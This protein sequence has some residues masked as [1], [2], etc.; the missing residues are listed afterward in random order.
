M[1]EISKFV[2]QQTAEDLTK[3]QRLQKVFNLI[4]DAERCSQKGIDLNNKL[5]KRGIISSLDK[6]HKKNM[7]NL[8]SKKPNDILK[9]YKASKSKNR[10][11]EINNILR[12]LQLW[13]IEGYRIIVQLRSVVTG[14]QLI[15]HIQDTQRTHTYILTEQEYLDLLKESGNA[16]MSYTTWKQIEEAVKKGSPKTKTDLF[17]ITINTSKTKLKKIATQNTYALTIDMNKDALYQ[18]L[19]QTRAITKKNTFSDNEEDTVN[20]HARLAELHTQM[21]SSLKWIYSNSKGNVAYPTKAKDSS[22]FFFTEERKKEVDNFIK[23]YKDEGL[24]VETD[25]FYLTGDATLDENTLIENKV[26]GAIIS[27]QTI[28]NAI[29]SIAALKGKSLETIKNNF[30]KL[31]T[32]KPTGELTKSIQEGAYNKAVASINELFKI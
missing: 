32:K 16:N 19:L 24:H 11:T 5:H 10:I 29:S 22:G 7:N 18:Y 15:Y 20:Y 31:F 14:Q 25:A 12:E 17:K 4:E 6:F 8:G 1:H 9:S 26:G 27:L 2:A 21:L 28:R 30:I 23:R 3:N 13:G